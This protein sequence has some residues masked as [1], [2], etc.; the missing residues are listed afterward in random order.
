MIAGTGQ[1]LGATRE[2]QPDLPSAERKVARA[3]ARGGGAVE[4][5]GPT[6][7]LRIGNHHDYEQIHTSTDMCSRHVRRSDASRD[8]SVKQ[9]RLERF[10]EQRC[11]VTEP[12]APISPLRRFGHVFTKV[13]MR[14]IGQSK[15][16]PKIRHVF[17]HFGD[18]GPG[19]VCP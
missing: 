17:K 9:A 8:P 5:R 12:C 19:E 13:E 10:I 11:L 2:G 3:S 18:H 7:P 15:S 14:Y 16:D 4:S 6:T 1:C